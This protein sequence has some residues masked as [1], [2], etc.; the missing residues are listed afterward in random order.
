MCISEMVLESDEVRA[1]FSKKQEVDL[2]M[3]KAFML[4]SQGLRAASTD[5][6]PALRSPDLM[7]VG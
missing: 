7:K 5:F 2:K 6:R 4:R 1:G 3:V